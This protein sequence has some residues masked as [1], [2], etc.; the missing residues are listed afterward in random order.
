[1]GFFVKTRFPPAPVKARRPFVF[2]DFG[3]MT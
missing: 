3:V 2:E 1:M